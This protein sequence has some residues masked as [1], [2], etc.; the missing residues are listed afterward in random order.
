MNYKT[1]EWKVLAQKDKAHDDIVTFLCELGNK[2]IISSSDDTSIKVWNV[3]SDNE[4]QLIR[5]L[6]QHN[7]KVDKVIALTYNRFA[8]CSYDNNTVKFMTKYLSLLNNKNV[9][10]P[11]IKKTKRS[12]YC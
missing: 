11:S 10:P 7:D 1:K 6:K 5:T 9:L 3:L 12:T 2:R 8:S 4:V